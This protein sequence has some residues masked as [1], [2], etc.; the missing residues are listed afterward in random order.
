VTYATTGSAPTTLAPGQSTP[1]ELGV[2][3][4]AERG[5]ALILTLPPDPPLEQTLVV[6][7]RP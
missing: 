7:T 3:L 5:L 6:E 2:P 1:F 4:P